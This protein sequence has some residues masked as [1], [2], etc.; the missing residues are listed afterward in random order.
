MRTGT[1]S[2]HVTYSLPTKELSFFL[3]ATSILVEY[4]DIWPKHCFDRDTNHAV[5]FYHGKRIIQ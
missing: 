5:I 2:K 3:Q 1:S 4:I